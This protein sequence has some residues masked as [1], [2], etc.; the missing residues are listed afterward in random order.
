M[1]VNVNAQ[2]TTKPRLVHVTRQNFVE[3]KCFTDIE[4]IRI[5]LIRLTQYKHFD[6]ISCKQVPLTYYNHVESTNVYCV[7]IKY[8]K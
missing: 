4:W 8:S 1:K 7:H 6:S 5:H 2:S 3:L